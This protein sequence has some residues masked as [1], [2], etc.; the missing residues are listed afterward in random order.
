MKRILFTVLGLVAVSL[1]AHAVVLLNDALSY[2]NGPLVTV[3]AGLWFTH[4]GTTGQV[5]VAAGRV[6]LTQAETEDVNRT[7]SPA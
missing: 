2:P 3:A 6:N 7:L 1:S 4:S 5:D